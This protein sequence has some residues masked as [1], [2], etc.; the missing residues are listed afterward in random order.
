MLWIHQGGQGPQALS[1]GVEG[2]TDEE[3][4]Q[5]NKLALK[6]MSLREAVRVHSPCC[7]QIKNMPNYDEAI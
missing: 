6:Q 1:V 2:H 5:G 7:L 4:S 3:N